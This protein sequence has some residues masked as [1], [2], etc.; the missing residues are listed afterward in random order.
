MKL[1]ILG[2]G[3]LARMMAMSARHLGI[4]IIC[5]N[6]IS[7]CSASD[8]TTVVAAELT[9]VEKIK[10]AFNGVDCVTYETENL[11]IETLQ[12]LSQQFKVLPEVNCLSIFQDRLLEKNFLQSAGIPTTEYM[13]LT[14]WQDITNA[15]TQFGFPFIIK[16]RL[17]GY[18]G[19]GQ[20]VITSLDEA[21]RAWQQFSGKPSIIEKFF[22]FDHEVSLIFARNTKGEVVYYPLILNQHKHGILFT[23]EAPYI[24]DRLQAI[25]KQYA[26]RMLDRLDYVGVM[27][28]EFFCQR[29]ALFVNEI[30]PRVHNSGHWTMEGAETSQ[31]ENHLRAIFGLP[32]GSTNVTGFSAMINFIGKACNKE[33]LL[34]LPGAHYHWYNKAVRA[35]RKLG[36]L[37]LCATSQSD[38]HSNLQAAKKIVME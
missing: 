4:E 28:I 21:E 35:G 8:I 31:F 10:E 14:C 16:T 11:P 27:T 36:H 1:G 20:A 34:S 24:N 32:L 26:E 29:D 13:E 33:K 22:R 5:I 15:I 12:L 19:K 17:S 2:G 37:T 38:L 25:A 6:P 3:Q 23:S 7:D 30:A 9:D 18:D